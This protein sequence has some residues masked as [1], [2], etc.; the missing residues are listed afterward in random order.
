MRLTEHFTRIDENT[1][2]YIGT[3]DDPKTWTKSWKIAMPLTRDSDYTMLRS[4]LPSTKYIL[5]YCERPDVDPRGA[6]QTGS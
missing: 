4:G 5:P 6:P 2:Q 3:I 1:I